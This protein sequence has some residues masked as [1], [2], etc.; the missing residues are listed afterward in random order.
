[1]SAR[2]RTPWENP[3]L[4]FACKVKR[5]RETGKLIF[6]HFPLI[7]LWH[8]F[9]YLNILSVC[10]K[11]KNFSIATELH[12]PPKP[13][14]TAIPYIYTT[15]KPRNRNKQ[16]QQQQQHQHKTQHESGKGS[17]SIKDA[18]GPNQ[19]QTRE[20]DAANEGT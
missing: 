17:G 2:V 7:N 19:I 9:P 10:F 1:M 6:P 3:T 8:I 11:Y 5:K 18:A 13:T 4:G 16:Q 20:N 14:T 15:P 12:L